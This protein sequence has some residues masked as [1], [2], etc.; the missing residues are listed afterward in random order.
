MDKQ[1]ENEITVM[2]QPLARR[3]A[4]APGPARHRRPVGERRPRGGYFD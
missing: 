4:A 1:L 2:C 3:P